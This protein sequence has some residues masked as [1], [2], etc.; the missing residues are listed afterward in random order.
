MNSPMKSPTH[1]ALQG[2]LQSLV[3]SNGAG[4]SIGLELSLDNDW[5]PAREAARGAE[6]AGVSPD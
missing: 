6:A 1:D 3:A 4:P 5:S 2:A